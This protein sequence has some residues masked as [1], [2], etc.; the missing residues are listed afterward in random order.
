MLALVKK[1][2]KPGLWMDEVPEPVCGDNDVKIKIHK[3]AICGTDLHIYNWNQWSQDTIQVPR[4]IGHEYVGEIVE[5][6]KNATR[7]EVGQIVS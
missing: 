4:V 1:Y 3:T 2:A 5:T 6:G 7:Y